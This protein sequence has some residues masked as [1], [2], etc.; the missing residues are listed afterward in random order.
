MNEEKVFHHYPKRKIF[1]KKKSYV[2]R[3]RINFVP[4]G[5]Y[6]GII[7][8]TPNAFYVSNFSVE[9]GHYMWIEKGTNYKFT[10][11]Q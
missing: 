2:S 6:C 8:H 1:V 9:S 4:N 11:S 5:F 3:Y 10:V 7:G